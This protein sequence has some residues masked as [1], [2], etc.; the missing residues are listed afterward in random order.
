M[1]LLDKLLG[2]ERSVAER[3]GM[4]DERTET[5]AEKAQLD[6]EAAAGETP[7]A[8]TADPDAEPS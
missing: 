8:R 3:T 6:R 7:G 2:R 1:G 4:S 5:S